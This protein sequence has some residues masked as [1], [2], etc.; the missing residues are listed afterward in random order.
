MLTVSYLSSEFLISSGVCT[1]VESPYR[2]DRYRNLTCESCG[3]SDRYRDVCRQS[4]RGVVSR[5]V[6]CSRP[7]TRENWCVGYGEVSETV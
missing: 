1:F 6:F 7:G 5:S 4:L 3:D 2:T